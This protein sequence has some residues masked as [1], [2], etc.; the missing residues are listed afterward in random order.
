MTCRKTRKSKGGKY[1]G[2]GSFGCS[3]R[4][5]LKCVGEE[6]V[7]QNAITKVLVEKDA[8]KE[9]KINQ[10]LSVI[11][12]EQIFTLYP[13]KMCKPIFYYYDK[14]EMGSSCDD[15]LK[16]KHRAIFLKDGGDNL[17]DVFLRVPK[18]SFNKVHRALFRALHNLF[19]GLE[20]LHSKN[21]VH[22]D[23]KAANVVCKITSG[24]ELK[25][26]GL[27]IGKPT[28]LMK[29]IDFGFSGLVDTVFTKKN[30][31]EYV[32]WPFEL[33]F[34]KDSYLNGTSLLEAKD[35]NIYL[36]TVANSRQNYVP[37]WLYKGSSI[38]PSIDD[39]NTILKYLKSLEP[40]GKKEMRRDIL[41]K[42]DVYSLGLLLS[43]C[44]YDLT[45][46]RKI[47]VNIFTDDSTLVKAKP[48]PALTGRQHD[49]VTV[50]LYDLVDKMT[51]PDFRKRINATDALQE[52]RTVLQ[53]IENYFSAQ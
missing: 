25:F 20:Y 22:L 7:E 42:A 38:L 40:E 18:H 36:N 41:K 3:F 23:I 52:F 19:I 27:K 10:L 4:P 33:R 47:G 21:F 12:P 9:F 11:D 13:Y 31:F 37:Y 6:T 28:Y 44:Y 51:Q 34:V 1:I 48:S 8:E 29:F 45:G 43:E 30:N 17:T 2:R 35:L 16:V 14:K 50:P 24:K 32:V 49:L 5:A 15:F 26:F 53:G 39:Y 46:I